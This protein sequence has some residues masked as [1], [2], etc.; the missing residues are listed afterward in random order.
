MGDAQELCQ[1]VGYLLQLPWRGEEE[2]EEERSM[3][4]KGTTGGWAGSREVSR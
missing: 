4:W 1:R 3:R 2:G